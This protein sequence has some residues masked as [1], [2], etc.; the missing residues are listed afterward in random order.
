MIVP[1]AVETLG[2]DTVLLHFG[3]GLDAA[4]NARVHDALAVIRAADLPG[5]VELV[6]AF[7]SLAVQFDAD[8]W[9]GGEELPS[10]HLLRAL[11]GLMQQP[12][13]AVDADAATVEI[14]VCYD[15]D[16]APDLA[17]AAQSLALS[18]DEVVRRHS[19]G[20]YRVAMLGFSPGFPYLLGLD[21]RLQLPRRATPR[22]RVPAGSV[23]I[24]GAQSGIYPRE[25]PGG[26]HL[27]GR[28][29]L[30]LFDLHRTPPNLVAVGASLR[31]RRI[32]R[33]EFAALAQGRA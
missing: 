27:I 33:D 9:S 22:T 28:T 29:P 14:P 6:P 15:G 2:Q 26:W 18:E 19:A 4:V 32:G 12:V 5:I 16:C 21:P 3:Q 8:T 23:A 31:F 24:G 17:E 13:P 30:N 25:L 1:V 20:L 7:A 10:T 11:E